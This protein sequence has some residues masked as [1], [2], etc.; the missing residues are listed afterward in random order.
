MYK[1]ILIKFEMKVKVEQKVKL[2]C[3]KFKPQRKRKTVIQA[4]INNKVHSL[5]MN[6]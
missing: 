4:T 6:L 1:P 2:P 3:K 5:G